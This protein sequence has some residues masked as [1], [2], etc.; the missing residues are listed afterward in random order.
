MH[1]V[2]AALPEPWLGSQT[3]PGEMNVTCAQFRKAP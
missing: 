2:P 1:A 3:R